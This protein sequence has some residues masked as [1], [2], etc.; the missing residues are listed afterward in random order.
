MPALDHQMPPYSVCVYSCPFQNTMNKIRFYA[1]SCSS[2]L[3][4]DI[5]LN[6]E[7]QTVRKKTSISGQKLRIPSRFLHTVKTS[8]LRSARSLDDVAS[9]VRP[10]FPGAVAVLKTPGA[11]GP[12]Y[13][14][15]RL[16]VM[17][18]CRGSFQVCVQPRRCTI[19][20]ITL[21]FFALILTEAC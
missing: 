6:C 15:C 19:T 7:N 20:F 2:K 17:D 11:K 8:L 4:E 18:P 13:G 9:N 14:S 16:L 5:L 3:Q 10:H 12:Y 1:K 21:L